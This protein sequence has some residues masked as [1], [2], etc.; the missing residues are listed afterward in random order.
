[1][2]RKERRRL[3]PVV[4]GSLQ[5]RFLAMVLFYGA[6]TVVFM[7]IFL[8]MPDLIAVSNEKLSFELRGAAAQRV[9]ATHYRLWPAIVSLICIL[10]IHSFRVFLRVIGPLYRM[11]LVMKQIAQGNLSIRLTFRKRDYLHREAELFN[12][13]M[14]IFEEKWQI[15]QA[16]GRDGLKSL[17][18]WEESMAVEREGRDSIN[19]ILRSYRQHLENLMEKAGYFQLTVKEEKKQES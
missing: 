13:M 16:L 17:S 10:G 3:F 12:Q 11:R 8:L 19:Q 15:V 14:K 2:K 9:L 6:I 5:Y 7:A 4:D 18:S 1:M